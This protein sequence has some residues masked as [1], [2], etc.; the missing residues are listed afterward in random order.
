[1]ANVAQQ[2]PFS[3]FVSRLIARPSA[4]L[5]AAA[6]D[7]SLTGSPGPI[8]GRESWNLGGTQ[9]FGP[10][11]HVPVTANFPL[12]EKLQEAVPLIDAAIVHTIEAIGT[13][14]VEA[15][16][17][18]KA[19]IDAWL[20]NLTVNRVQTGVGPFLETWIGN[21]LTYGR[22]HTEIV[23]TNA[24][25]DIYSLT[26]LHPST[27]AFSAARDGYT[28]DTVQYGGQ[29]PI[30]FPAWKVLNAVNR[31]RGDDPNG[32]SLL[33]GLS[34][35]AECYIAMVRGQQGL[36]TRFGD[37]SHHVNWEPPDNFNDP[38]GAQSD[39]IMAR[40]R[41]QFDS[42][43]ASRRDGKVK[44][45]FTSGKVTVSIIGAAGEELQFSQS[46]Q[47][48]MEQIVAKT[49]LPPMIFGLNWATTERMSTV[50]SGL[51]SEMVD[52]Y[53]GILSP[54]LTRLIT[55][56]QQL[57]G[58]DTNFS[59]KWEGA[60][61]QDRMMDAQ[62]DEQEEKAKAAAWE[63]D[64][65]LVRQGMLTPIEWLRRNRPDLARLDDEEL[66]AYLP[67]FDPNPPEPAALPAFG[68]PANQ[69]NGGQPGRNQ[70]QN[71]NRPPSTQRSLTYAALWNEEN[72]NGH[73]Q[74]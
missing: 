8:I 44:D 43:Q 27:I 3:R 2:S 73:G 22:S 37:P 74:H 53:Q 55:L 48:I 20:R 1:M 62:A 41:A 4:R 30:V 65:K 24:R 50:Q 25:D 45:Y 60:N 32:T 57:R 18:V 14:C 69:S 68:G 58:G 19:D 64:L 35:V 5:P 59:L 71:N 10:Y 29:T 70:G 33:W 16:K 13:P 42:S 47:S 39:A 12:Y 56:R 26:Q 21:M 52:R 6:R 38:S 31:V 23:L 34:I 17:E 63:N 28:L 61:L 72:G 15:E 67:D 54:P 66:Q 7:T 49:G 36:Y 46:G 40:M 51:L 11:T 9:L